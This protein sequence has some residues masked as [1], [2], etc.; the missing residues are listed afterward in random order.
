MHVVTVVP[1]VRGTPIEELSYYTVRAVSVGD[2][3]TVPIRNKDQKGL[4]VK[5]D[6]VEDTKAQLRS[7]DFTLQKLG[8]EPPSPLLSESHIAMCVAVAQNHACSIGAVVHSIVPAALIEETPPLYHT[9]EHKRGAFQQ[10]ALQDTFEERI[11]IYKNIARGAYR[12]NNQ[13]R[14]HRQ[15][16][17]MFFY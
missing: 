13:S 1:I 10:L 14:R 9:S 15:G 11:A 16:S 3:V 5:V 12:G 8:A 17:P 7:Q 6:T 4:V 2:I